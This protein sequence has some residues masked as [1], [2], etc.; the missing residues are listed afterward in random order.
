[1]ILFDKCIF[2]WKVYTRLQSGGTKQLHRNLKLEVER[3]SI[4]A[5]ILNCVFFFFLKGLNLVSLSGLSSAV[6]N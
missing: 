3:P 1:M 5:Q 4:V 2:S 6:Y